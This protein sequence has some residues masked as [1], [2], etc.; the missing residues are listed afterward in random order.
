MLCQTVYREGDHRWLAFGQDPD[1]PDN[2]VDTNQFV[3]DAGGTAILVDPGGIEIF[4]AML[5]ALSAKLPLESIRHILLSHQDPDIG[6]SLPLWREVCRPDVTIHI[7]WLWTSF[8]SH[9]DGEAKLTAIPDAGGEI[10]LANDVVLQIIPAHFLH[11][12]GNFHLYDPK[13]RILFS[14]DVGA[15]LVPKRVRN[16]IYVEEFSSH[17]P[18]MEQWHRRAMGSERARDAWLSRVSR[19]DVR[20]LAPQ[21]GL[22]L[23]GDDVQRFYDWFGRLPIGDGIDA[24]RNG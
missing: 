6:S 12:P 16:S 20:I 22:L 3:V 15:S 23:R 8:V 1:R 11:S 5:G 19:L 7:S 9:F 4:P 24:I 2:I 13:A 18:Y 14:A 21:H 10:K 17:I